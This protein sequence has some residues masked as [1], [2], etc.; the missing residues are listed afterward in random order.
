MDNSRKLATLAQI[1]Y[2]ANLLAIPVIGLLLLLSLLFT[3]RTTLD[4]FSR[5]HFKLALMT[6][7]IA[8]LLLGI[9]ALFFWQLG[10]NSAEAWT[11]LLM[12]LIITHT[13][14]V[15]FGIFALARA[16]TGKRLRNN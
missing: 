5:Y 12:Y 14:M 8:I 4:T 2:L 13:S 16:M 3:L 15:T 1:L 11:T 9:P 10:Y 7:T 6:G